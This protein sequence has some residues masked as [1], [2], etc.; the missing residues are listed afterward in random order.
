MY[1]QKPQRAVGG[2]NNTITTNE[3]EIIHRTRASKPMKLNF[4]NLVSRRGEMREA[5][6]ED[7]Q[8][9]TRTST[10]STLNEAVPRY[11]KKLPRYQT[12]LPRYCEKQILL[13]QLPWKLPQ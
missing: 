3:K 5:Q 4:Q 13:R 9:Q 12:K 8:P 10:L 11:Q 2:T 6:M 7:L 1:D